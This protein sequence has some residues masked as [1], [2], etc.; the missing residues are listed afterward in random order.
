MYVREGP[1]LYIK[2][3][4]LE[5]L[6]DKI[7]VTLVPRGSMFYKLIDIRIITTFLP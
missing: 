3:S 6:F 5:L 1:M 4:I 2:C 7:H